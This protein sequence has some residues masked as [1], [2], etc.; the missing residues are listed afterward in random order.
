M[1][2]SVN[3]FSF[4]IFAETVAEMSC[5]FSGGQDGWTSKPQD[6]V[7]SSSGSKGR[8]SLLRQN[9]LG[10]AVASSEDLNLSTL[11]AAIVAL[12]LPQVSS[13]HDFTYVLLKTEVQS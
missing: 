2:L 10:S 6:N 12:I 8:P 3:V 11:S 1:E 7:I 5:P 9:T 13:L 4:S